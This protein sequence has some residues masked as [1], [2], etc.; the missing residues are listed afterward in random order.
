MAL[1]HA[2]ILEVSIRAEHQGWACEGLV[3]YTEA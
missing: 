2:W 1:V 3:V